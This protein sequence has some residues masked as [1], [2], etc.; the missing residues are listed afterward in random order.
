M[1]ILGFV[2]HWTPRPGS[3]LVCTHVLQLPQ[4]VTTVGVI[5]S[6]PT[7]HPCPSKF[8][9]SQAEVVA[10]DELELN[11]VRATLNLGHTFGHAIETASGYGTWLHGEA[12][13]AGTCMAADLSFRLVRPWLKCGGW[14]AP[15]WRQ[16]SRSGSPHSG[17]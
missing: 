4:P 6:Y 12:V 11:D 13:A 2:L 16:A 8:T 10:A 15:A 17:W 3:L 7:N 9:L 1:I 5:F 14:G